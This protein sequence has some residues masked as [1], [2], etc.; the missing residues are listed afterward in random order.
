MGFKSSDSP[1][2]LPR[3]TLVPCPPD[4][5]TSVR[6]ILSSLLGLLATNVSAQGARLET[7][8]GE[9]RVVVSVTRT[10]RI[11]PDR[12][13][14]YLLVEGSGETP[15]DA[16]QRAGQKLQAV[17]TAVRQSGIAIESAAALPYGVSPAPNLNGYPGASTQTSYVARFALRVQLTK[18]EQILSLTATAMTAG[19]GSASAPVFEASAADSAR[20]ARFA[21]ALATARQ[22]AEALASSLGGRLG[23]LIE[24]SSSGMVGQG[25][26]SPY[27]SFMNRY[28]MS[29]QTQSPDVHVSATVT[30]R[31]RFIP[32]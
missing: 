29:G 11:S 6:I 17:T 31:Y 2:P 13:T 19:A 26:S 15:A 5:R 24:V 9:P 10:A 14:V 4:V 27:I 18:L 30:V 3:V 20:R 32:H 7:S 21:E 25:I 22:D 28:D 1:F 12:A 8:D 16:A 23:G